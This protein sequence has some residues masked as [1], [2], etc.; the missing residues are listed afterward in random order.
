[1]L[2]SETLFRSFAKNLR[3]AH[4]VLDVERHLRD[5][6]RCAGDAERSPRRAAWMPCVAIQQCSNK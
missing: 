6:E 1:M 3:S 5:V 2:P 4:F